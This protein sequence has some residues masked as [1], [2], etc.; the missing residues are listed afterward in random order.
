MGYFTSGCW[1]YPGGSEI[2]ARLNEAIDAYERRKSHD[3]ASKIQALHFPGRE[4]LTRDETWTAFSPG[5]LKVFVHGLP[6]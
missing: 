5:E 2:V 4:P 1:S 6:R 3:A